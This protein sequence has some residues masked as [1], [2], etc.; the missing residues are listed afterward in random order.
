MDSLSHTTRKFNRFELIYLITLQQAEKFKT[1]RSNQLS[2]RIFSP[3]SRYKKA[4][5]KSAC[6]LGAMGLIF[7]PHTPI[8]SIPMKKG[9]GNQK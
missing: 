6:D 8:Q 2:L 9:K 4:I 7:K 1:A 5:T 3:N